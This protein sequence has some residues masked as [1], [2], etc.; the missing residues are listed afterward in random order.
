MTHLQSGTS[1]HDCCLRVPLKISPNEEDAL[2]LLVWAPCIRTVLVTTL[3][4]DNIHNLAY[5]QS[6]DTRQWIQV[7]FQIRTLPWAW[8][9]FTMAYLQQRECFHPQQQPHLHHHQGSSVG[10]LLRP[11]I[12]M[13][14]IMIL[15]CHFQRQEK[16]KV[17]S[18]AK[19][20]PFPELSNNVYTS[21]NF[22]RCGC[23]RPTKNCTGLTTH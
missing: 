22:Y 8:T 4:Q 14:V 9:V 15:T 3:N 16:M 2:A 7:W 19:C 23:I 12:P 6:L 10:I 1:C 21:M 5:L 17:G 20:L 18:E 11:R 13:N